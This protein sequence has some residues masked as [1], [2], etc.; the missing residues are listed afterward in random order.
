MCYVLLASYV[1][2]LSHEQ[3]FLNYCLLNL[4]VALVSWGN[5]AMWS[6]LELAEN[7]LFACYPKLESGLVCNIMSLMFK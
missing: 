3:R 2:T 6:T 5:G 1:I 4:H 7:Q